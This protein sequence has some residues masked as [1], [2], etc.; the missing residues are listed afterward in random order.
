MDDDEVIIGDDGDDDIEPS[1]DSQVVKKE[2]ENAELRNTFIQ[3]VSLC[4]QYFPYL[5]IITDDKK[6]DFQI[7]SSVLPLSTQIV[8]GFTVD[9]KLLNV[10]ITL[11]DD[12][13]WSGP[14]ESSYSSHPI[15]NQSYYGRPLVLDTIRNF[16]SKYY[17]PKSDYRAC[18]YAFHPLGEADKNLHQILISE[19]FDSGLAERALILNKNDI[20]KSRNFLLTGE[21]PL[22]IIYVPISFDESPLVFLVLEIIECF[23]DLSDHCCICRK[24]LP[25]SGIRPHICDKKLC[26]VSFN[27]IGVGTSVLQEIKRDPLAADFIVSLFTGSFVNEKYMDPKPPSYIKECMRTV[28]KQLPSMQNIV[29]QCKNDTDISKKFG[30]EALEFLRWVLMSNRSQVISLTGNQKIPEIPTNY[31]FMTLIASPETEYEFLIRKDKY[32]STFLWHGSG[33]ERWHSILR[34]GLRNM[35]DVPGEAIHGKAFGSGIYFA[36]ESNVSCSYSV[37]APVVNSYKKSVIGQRFNV[38][39]LCEVAPV[40]NK[41]K[42]HGTCYTLSD[43]KACIVRFMIPFLY[44]FNIGNR[45]KKIPTLDDIIKMQVTRNKEDTKMTKICQHRKKSRL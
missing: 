37:M 19:G 12:F 24:K 9:P 30:T 18:P 15:Y 8:C 6:V 31:Q 16:F 43:E 10:S 36:K 40:K 22:N 13:D 32:G 21:L 29:D 27:E 3:Q 34:N 2:I 39:A 41:L 14:I 44:N 7:P 25:F 45:I 1:Q 38:L 23:L 17:E 42:D 33:G 20:E 26:N 5:N 4:S 28:V 35:S 11:N